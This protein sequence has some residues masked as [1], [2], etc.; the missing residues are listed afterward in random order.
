MKYVYNRNKFSELRKINE[1]LDSDKIDVDF[2]DTL[3]GGTLNRLMG[4]VRSNV[5]DAS[6]KKYSK[7]LDRTLA[8]MLVQPSLEKA[9]E[10]KPEEDRVDIE[11]LEEEGQQIQSSIL[12]L[13]AIKLYQEGER[14]KSQKMLELIPEE[15][16]KGL[17][18]A[19]KI[20]SLILSKEDSQFKEGDIALYNNMEVQVI[21]TENG[22][23]KV[24]NEKGEEKEVEESELVLKDENIEDIDTMIDTNIKV[25][26]VVMYGDIKVKVLSIKENIAII[27]NEKGEEIEVNL[28]ELSSDNID[29][30]KELKQIEDYEKALNHYSKICT[31]NSDN[32]NEKTLKRVNTI[33]EKI[34]YL[35]GKIKEHLK[36]YNVL[37]NDLKIEIE[38]KLNILKE[39]ANKCQ[40]SSD[41]NLNESI[42]LI[43]EK[44]E[45][46]VNTISNKEFDKIKKELDKRSKKLKMT[47]E[48]LKKL[49]K[50]LSEDKGINEVSGENA[51]KIIDILTKAK[52]KLI[53]S[54]PYDELLKKQKRYFD[55]LDSGRAISRKAYQNWVKDVTGIVNFYKGKMPNSVITAI[56]DSLDK[57][58]ISNDY[59]KLNKVFLGIDKRRETDGDIFKKNKKETGSSIESG[60]T[61]NKLKFTG[62]SQLTMGDKLCFVLEITGS[63]GEGGY[64]TGLVFGRR[65]KSFQFK[66]ILGL[67]IKWLEGYY[68]GKEI[69]TNT[70]DTETNIKNSNT[71]LNNIKIGKTNQ[72]GNVFYGEMDKTTIKKG[73]Q[74][75]VKYLNFSEDIIGN[76]TDVDGDRLVNEQTMNTLKYT[77]TKWQ[78]KSIGVLVGSEDLKTS[79][80]KVNSKNMDKTK[81][82]FYS[83]ELYKQI[84]EIFDD[85]VEGSPIDI[86]NLKEGDEIR[87]RQ[88]NGN[89]NDAVVGNKKDMVGDMLRVTTEASPGGFLINKKD[90][91][92]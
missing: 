55:K 12:Y 16:L 42:N 19:P 7:E 52:N 85:N 87:Y 24:E 84:T 20:T 78:I 75:N 44:E 8:S 9:N 32:I 76:I 36:K 62:M 29:N 90:I 77:T 59:V 28:S 1:I 73:D 56:S 18:E 49:N 48:D 27:K 47:E 81:D 21:S 13:D 74:V 60:S 2:S 57:E 31:D 35:F 14:E 71:D 10:D 26:S 11:T 63:G 86:D 41:D 83:P 70:K 23:V 15:V 54:K 68:T 65:G 34:D 69:E 91:I 39:I 17:P 53:T 88:K 25:G 37:D 46:V 61:D 30:S 89:I 82:G 40:G 72:Y 92:V 51:K 5:T 6:M 80:Y 38:S 66:F 67:N 50:E 64:I 45:D 43:L 58:A 22:L 4:F 3:I 33:S 79:T